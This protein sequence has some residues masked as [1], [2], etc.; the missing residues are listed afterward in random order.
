[1]LHLV[2][3]QG[4]SV[5]IVAYDLGIPP[6]SSTLTLSVLIQVSFIQSTLKIF[7]CQNLP[8]S[9]PVSPENVKKARN[10][11]SFLV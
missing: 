9:V 5:K 6:L 4:M 7:M 11:R 2:K 1:L 3:D 10:L 8:N